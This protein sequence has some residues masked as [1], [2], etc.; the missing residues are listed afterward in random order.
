[1][2]HTPVC[3]LSGWNMPVLRAAGGKTKDFVWGTQRFGLPWLWSRWCAFLTG[4]RHRLRSQ[5][6]WCYSLWP[7][8]APSSSRSKVWMISQIVNFPWR[9]TWVGWRS[10]PMQVVAQLHSLSRSCCSTV[11]SSCVLIE[12]CTRQSSANR[13]TCEAM[14]LGR[15]LMYNRNNRGPWP[16]PM[17]C[18]TLRI[19]MWRW[20]F[21]HHALLPL[22][23]EYRYPFPD[24][25]IL[26]LPQ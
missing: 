25:I 5:G 15:S 20:S 23:Q 19:I 3:N 26:Q 10:S 2:K 11:A 6:M 16:F 13:H 9:S 18:L 22:L 24:T 1:M 12:Q 8:P 4:G 7:P 14:L 21:N 17:A